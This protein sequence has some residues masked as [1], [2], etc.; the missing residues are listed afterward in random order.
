LF[1]KPH[2][3]YPLQGEPFRMNPLSLKMGGG[4]ELERG[5][6]APSLIYTPPSLYKI[7]REG[8]QGG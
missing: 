1:D 2:P 7:A 6:E 4:R 5:G 8:G 3:L